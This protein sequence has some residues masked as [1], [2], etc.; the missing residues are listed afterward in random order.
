M[1]GGSS[2]L[3]VW[4]LGLSVRGA[5]PELADLG[6]AMEGL[7]QTLMRSAVPLRLRLAALDR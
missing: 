6:T 5:V 7:H 3:S 2:W 4:D 1:P